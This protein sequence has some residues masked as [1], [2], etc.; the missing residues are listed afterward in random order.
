MMIYIFYATFTFSV[1]KFTFPAE[2]KQDCLPATQSNE[3]RKGEGQ[4][5]SVAEI[6]VLTR[7]LQMPVRQPKRAAR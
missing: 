4:N 5:T 6:M 7:R 3:S 1:C 2:V